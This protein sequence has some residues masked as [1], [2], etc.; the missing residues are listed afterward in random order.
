MATLAPS[1]AS[2][3][4]TRQALAPVKRSSSALLRSEFMMDSDAVGSF[5]LPC[6][7]E[8]LWALFYYLPRNHRPET[9]LDLGCGTG[10]LTEAMAKR[11]PEA[12][13]TAV[14]KQGRM[15]ATTSDRVG[16]ANLRLLQ[17]DFLEMD[18]PAS[19]YDVVMTRLTL[20]H[21]DDFDKQRVLNK[22]Y[23][24]LQPGGV[25]VWAE[26]VSGVSPRLARY[27]W[28]L[29]QKLS[30]ENGLEEERIEAL[31]AH[32]HAQDRPAT[33]R[34]LLKWMEMAGFKH[35]DAVWRYGFWS[36]MIGEK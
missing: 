36:V 13:I 19:Y 34:E 21:L 22:I 27:D 26:Q 10:V 25:F 28:E 6:F 4:A 2:V 23:T 29:C 15:L 16:R 18:W 33:Q 11:W 35:V 12:E 17:D 9:V 30:R 20:H 24:A 7:D 31:Y 3:L 14:D 5:A 8:M 32:V 1:N